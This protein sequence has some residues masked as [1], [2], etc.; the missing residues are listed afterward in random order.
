MWVPIVLTGA[1]LALAYK[2]AKDKQTKPDSVATAQ[3]ETV[4]QQ[5]D[6]TEIDMSTPPSDG[7][8]DPSTQPS[9]GGAD[10]STQPSPDGAHVVHILGGDPKP[11]EYTSHVQ[12]ALLKYGTTKNLT[13]KQY[14]NAQAELGALSGDIW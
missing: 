9:V 11:P 1:G 3:T 4:T 12:A 10:P 6:A 7:G 14:A 8:A 13:A 2:L 5:T